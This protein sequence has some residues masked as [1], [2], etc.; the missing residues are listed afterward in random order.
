[1]CRRDAIEHT[2]SHQISK[3]RPDI[4]VQVGS[5]RAA[6][7][8]T[9][10]LQIRRASSDWTVSDWTFRLGPE[11]HCPRPNIQ[12]QTG[13]LNSAK[14]FQLRLRRHSIAQTA[15]ALDQ[16]SSCIP[17]QIE[18]PRIRR[19]GSDSEASDKIFKRRPHSH[20]LGPDIQ[21]QTGYACSVWT[22]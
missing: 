10:E 21:A 12:G 20:S 16:R 13:H 14:A 2:T 17:T 7:S 18:K 4:P 9:R 8:R 3:L 15:T 11:R 5:C 6:Q 19:A 22:A 1:M